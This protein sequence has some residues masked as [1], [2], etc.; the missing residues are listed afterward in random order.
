MPSDEP[1]T[2]GRL[3]TW[4][5]DFLRQRG[6]DSPQLDAQLLLAHARHCRRIDLFTA[7]NELATETERRDFRELVRQRSE[8]TPVAYLTGTRE[9]YS[10]E[11]HITRDVLVP[12]PETEFVV[13]ALLDLVKAHFAQAPSL[14][15]ADVGTGSG[16]LATC[17]ARHVPQSRVW[18]TDIS[19]RALAV[20]RENCQRHGVADRVELY[21]G[22]LLATVPPEVRFDFVLSNPPYV[23]EPE[24]A[25]LGRDVRD[26]EPRQALVAGP[27][28]VEVIERLVPAAADRLQPGGWLLLE[29]SPMIER[30]VHEVITRDGRYA[31]ALTSPDLA[32]H[33]RVVQAVIRS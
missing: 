19:P 3:L 32:G 5:T 24:Y 14:S 2:I 1:W 25:C 22:D 11:F 23:S 8:G 10:L 9:F 30:A 21:E 17:A 13:L 29:I 16:I 26:F 28:G 27:T 6:S 31:T 12:R 18:A 20:A 15:I 4:T 7:Y 33:A